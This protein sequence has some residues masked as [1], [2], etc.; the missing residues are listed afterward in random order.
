MPVTVEKRGTVAVVT[1]NN[2]PVNAIGKAERAGL[3]QAAS[4]LATEDSIERVVLTGNDGIF[5]AGADA[6]EFASDPQPPHLPDVI[7][8]IEQSPVPWIAAINGAALGGGAEIALGCRYRI[9]SPAATIGFPEVNLGIVPGAGGTQRLPRL[10]GMAQAL[11]IISEGRTLKAGDA[12]G[13]GFIDA[14]E[15]DPLSVASMI[16]L[17]AIFQRPPLADAAHPDADDIAIAAARERVARHMRQQIAPLEA[18]NL[19]AATVSL[20]FEEGMAMERA[21]FLKLRASDQAKALRHVFFAERAAKAPEPI[22]SARP[23]EVKQAVVAGG[24]NTGASIAFALDKAGIGVNIVEMD[25]E[26]ASQARC[27]IARLAGDAEQSGILPAEGATRI[28]ERIKVMV[29]YDQLPPAELGIEAASEDKAVKIQAFA[30]LE[31]SLPRSAILATSKASH[32]INEI[33]LTLID[34]G[35]V[36]GLHFGGPA[37]ATRLLEIVRGDASSNVALATGFALG[38][39]LRKIPVLCG[40]G[41][42]LIGNRILARYREATDKLLMDG[43]TP[44]D[45]DGAMTEFGYQMGPCEALELQGFDRA[46]TNRKWQALAKSRNRHALSGS[47]IQDR[48]V[49]AMINEAAAILDEGVAKAAADIDLVTIHG[50]GFPRWRG[51]LLFYAGTIGIG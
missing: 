20:P 23:L 32:L 24:G 9:A 51:G 39:K 31:K 16:D 5:A 22:A 15:T 6:R 4:T 38:K 2:P 42:G 18:I 17:A 36:I 1:I 26:S 11:G 3:L 25:D 47:E 8:T 30:S 10:I 45:I 28:K 50:C 13:I 41:D 46:D 14:V 35:R 19:V 37:H 27:N 43:A 40:V 34:P 33:A 44:E 29:G 12:A 49:T 7:A 48:L 21:S